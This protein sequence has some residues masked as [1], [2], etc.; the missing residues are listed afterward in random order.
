MGQIHQKHPRFTAQ[1]PNRAERARLLERV[2]THGFIDDYSGVPISSTGQR[3]H[4]DQATVWNL[5]DDN[6]NKIGQAAT[7]AQW[8]KIQD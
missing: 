2:T 6:G 1:A 4:I 3:F 5:L 8:T 7:F